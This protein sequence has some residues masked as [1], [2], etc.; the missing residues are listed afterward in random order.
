MTAQ[1]PLDY[2]VIFTPPG[3]RFFCAE[4]VSHVTDAVNLAAAGHPDTGLRILQPGE[5]LTSAITLTPAGAATA[6]PAPA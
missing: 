5:T 6:T 3:R 1:S 4:P 2:L